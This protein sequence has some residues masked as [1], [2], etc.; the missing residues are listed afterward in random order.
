[1]P[2]QQ[3]IRCGKESTRPLY[4][5]SFNVV[6]APGGWLLV[7]DGKLVGAIG[8]SGGTGDEDEVVAKAAAEAIK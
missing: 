5:L 7:S 2:P 4:F 3:G 6:A 1:L 8:V